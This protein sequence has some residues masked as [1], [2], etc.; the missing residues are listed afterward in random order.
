[1]GKGT[2]EEGEEADEWTLAV[3]KCSWTWSSPWAQG[4]RAIAVKKKQGEEARS[5]A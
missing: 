5:G 4:D 1:M 2:G 3:G